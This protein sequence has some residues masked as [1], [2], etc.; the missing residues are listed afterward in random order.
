M[1][2]T[3]KTPCIMKPGQSVF[4]ATPAYEQ[5]KPGYA[6][7]LAMTVSELTKCGIPFS[8]AVMYGNCHV[9]DGRN[10]LVEI[11]LHETE[12]TDLVFVDADVMWD[13]DTFMRLIRHDQDFVAGAYPFKNFP[14][15]YPIGKFLG[16]MTPD[17]LVSV[18][19]AATGFMRIR[20]KVF[21]TLYP[22]QRR[23]KT[24]ARFFERDEVI[25]D[26]T[27]RTEFFER[28]GSS[29]TYDGGDVTFCR[30]ALAAGFHCMVDTTLSLSHIG[31]WR[32]TG[33]F[34]DHI[35]DVKN[36]ALHTVE[37]KDPVP[38]YRPDDDL[39]PVAAVM[40]LKTQRHTPDRRPPRDREDN[41]SVWAAVDALKAG[42]PDFTHF[43]TLCDAYGNQPW[44]ATPEYLQQAYD[45]VMQM[46]NDGR[47]L[48]CGSG[49]STLVLACAAQRQGLHHTVLE[50]DERWRKNTEDWLRNF[51]LCGP[52]GLPPWFEQTTLV[53]T[54][55]GKW[56]LTAPDMGSVDFIVIDGPPR[57]FG[58]D[59]LH[60]LR[61]PWIGKA[62]CLID[63]ASSEVIRQL[64]EIKGFWQLEQMGSRPAVIGK[65]NVEPGEIH[66]EAA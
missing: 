39:A 11:F 50:H 31:E 66:S 54:E 48:E 56:Y 24:R 27:E 14:Y 25:E 20:R 12:C 41:P 51:D 63:D 36:L 33:R 18:S 65:V 61:Q 26:S 23:C 9:D 3:Y 47:I 10:A 32:W 44:T 59:R 57:C 22:S 30:K 43:A 28:R 45:L 58:G 40:P 42:N 60:P 52:N 15:R 29:R 4:I 13:A 53:D 19:Y 38:D 55:S 2:A 49:L 17:G 5:V 35:R 6:Y 8:L 1:G 46:P 62:V 7:A 34:I 64:R 21:E 37:S 16:E